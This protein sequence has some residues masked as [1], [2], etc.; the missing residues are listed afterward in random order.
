VQIPKSLDN[1]LAHCLVRCPIQE[2]FVCGQKTDPPL[3]SHVVTFPRLEIPLKG[4]YE[5]KIEQ[6]K[7]TATVHLRPGTALFAAPN[8]WNLPTWR[9]NVELISLLF[10]KKHIGISH[11]IGRGL[12]RPQMVAEKFSIAFPLGGPLPCVLDAMSELQSIGKPR[13]AFTGLSLAL[14]Q[15]VRDLFQ[16]PEK[17]AVNRAQSLL[18]SICVYLQNHYQYDISRVF[19][20]QQFG[21]TPNHLSR[22]FKTHGS[23]TFNN[24]LTHVRVNRSKY[25]LTKYNLKLDDIAVRCGFRDTPYFCRVFK[26]LTK[27]TPAAYRSTHRS[28]L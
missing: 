12:N 22:L 4:D 5:N 2:V 3:F 15:I 27:G 24:Y 8:C 1:L 11:V 19:V 26:R 10:G 18:E 28:H 23:M 16:N 13:E 6:E 21:I 20:A 7:D 14:I 9:L 25:L 17:L